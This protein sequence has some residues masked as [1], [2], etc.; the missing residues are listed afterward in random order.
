MEIRI[1]HLDGKLPNIALMK[2]SHWHKSNGDNVHFYR[3]ARKELFEPKYDVVY[4]SSI[5]SF[6]EK[7]QQ[8]FL[9]SFPNAIVGGTGFKSLKTIEAHIGI[10]RYE[11]YDYKLYPEFENSIGF[12]QRGCRLKCK[13]CVVGKKEGA[14]VDNDLVANIWRG[15]PYPKNL[16]LLDNDFFGQPN[17]ESK[18]NEIIDGNFR[19]CF[20]QGINIRLIDDKSAQVLPHI[21]YYDNKFK[22]RRLYTAWDNLGDEKIF[23]KGAKKLQDQGIP[24]RHLMVYMLIGF[25]KNETMG[26]ILYRFNILKNLGCLAY[27]M[28]YNNKDKELKRFQK[29]AVRRYHEFVAWED[30]SAAGA[31]ASKKNPAQIAMNL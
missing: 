25:K 31:R 5:F 15:D 11:K 12:T 27:P 26:D 2:L 24:M 21:Q 8:T 1:T 4:G 30:Y 19:A 7:K 9:K 18:A 23:L 17:W 6:N 3:T 28:V 20:C 29:W 14:N 13:F 10:L 22:N 16:I